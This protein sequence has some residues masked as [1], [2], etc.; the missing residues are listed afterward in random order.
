MPTSPSIADHRFLFKKPLQRLVDTQKDPVDRQS[1]ETEWLH[2]FCRLG[3]ERPLEHP[4]TLYPYK[5]DLAAVLV[6]EPLCV[7][8]LTSL[9]SECHNHHRVDR[10]LRESHLSRS[11]SLGQ[12]ELAPLWQARGY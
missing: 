5:P 6:C 12:R 7:Q 10:H 3:C 8:P 4:R 11:T 9:R 1:S 2:L